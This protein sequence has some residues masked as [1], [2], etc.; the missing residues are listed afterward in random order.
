MIRLYAP[1]R[2]AASFVQVGAGAGRA[3]VA[4]G[5]FAGMVPIDSLQLEEE[6]HDGAYAEAALLVGP[7]KQAVE[8]AERHG[9][10]Q[11]TW[12]L[13]APN[14]DGIPH[15]LVAFIRKSK[16]HGLVAPSQWA[17]SVLR[18]LTERTLVAP[19][20]VARHIYKPN[21]AAAEDNVV[22]YKKGQ[23]RVLHITS[24]LRQ[25][26]G[27][28]ELLQAWKL[29]RLSGALPASATLAIAANPLHVIDVIR[30]AEDAEVTGSVRVLPGFT[31]THEQMAEVYRRAHVVCQPSR[32]EGFG[33]I[34]L[35][36]RACGTPVVMTE[37][38][39]HGEHA[40][41]GA[42]PDE[43]DGFAFP[44]S[45]G[46][47]IAKTGADVAIDDYLGAKAPSLAP[48]DLAM[49][50]ANAHAAWIELCASAQQSAERVGQEWA[51]EKTMAQAIGLM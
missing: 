13:I 29:C 10:H 36:A 50:L 5:R 43:A 34:P 31:F 24:S 37:A 28:A 21:S 12:L 49:A 14:S 35:E 26:K 3:L 32:G 9:E 33:M 22:D 17:A 44:L 30:A 45:T 16:L 6:H 1:L 4:S 25:R 7:P 47:V 20:G 40:R 11:R 15:D 48:E 18:G 27:T 46:V 19:H 51:W 38:T 42:R 41:W 23:F 8:I 39:G 2:A